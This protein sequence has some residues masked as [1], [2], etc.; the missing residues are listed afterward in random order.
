MQHLGKI[1]A[2]PGL[3]GHAPVLLELRANL[4]VENFLEPGQAIRNRAH[5]AA[6]LHVVLAT[7]RVAP[8][9]PATDVPGE[10]AQVD[11]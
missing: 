8:A 11:Q 2:M 1:L 5:I 6:T 7:Q 4:G 10:Q 3:Q 9:A